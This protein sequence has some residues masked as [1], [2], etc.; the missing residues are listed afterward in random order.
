[1]SETSSITEYRLTDHARLEM[2]RRQVSEAEVVRVLSAPEQTVEV[3]PGRVVCQS[4]V[5]H[6]TP[7]RVYLLRVFVDVDRQP[8]EVVTV[9]RTSRIEKYWRKAT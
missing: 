2:E 1:M 5:K 8:A 9:Y 3:R 7:V 4:R 6:G